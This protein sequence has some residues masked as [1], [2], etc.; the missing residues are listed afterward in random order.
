M[1]VFVVVDYPLYLVSFKKDYL[2]LSSLQN[3]SCTTTE[4][5]KSK[6]LCGIRLFCF[7]VVFSAKQFHVD[8]IFLTINQRTNGSVNAHLNTSQV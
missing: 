4:L 3:S 8:D 5:S 2:K 6:T 1:E 7:L